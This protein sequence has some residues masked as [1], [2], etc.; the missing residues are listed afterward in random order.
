MRQLVKKDDE[1]VRVIKDHDGWKIVT[2]FLGLLV[3]PRLVFAGH[4]PEGPV[5]GIQ[6]KEEADKLAAQWT[7][8]LKKQDEVKRK[9]RRRE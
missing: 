1:Y 4:D 8:I 7:E 9:K 6:D 2:A 3:G 5:Q